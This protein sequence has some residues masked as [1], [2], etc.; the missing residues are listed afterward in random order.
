MVGIVAHCTVSLLLIFEFGNSNF[1]IP[2]SGHQK[3]RIKALTITEEFS[4]V[5][6]TSWKAV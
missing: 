4:N 2:D 5:M 1:Q 6:T 3:K